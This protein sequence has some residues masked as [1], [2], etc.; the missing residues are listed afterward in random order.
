MSDDLYLFIDFDDTLSDA[1]T[2]GVQYVHALSERLASAYG[3][4][5]TAW[6]EALVPELGAG[7]AR[8]EAQF[9]GNPLGGYTAWLEEERARTAESLFRS[10]GRTLPPE[11]SPAE[12]AKRIQFDALTAVHAVYPGAAE[13]LKRLS[14]AGVRLMMAS[15]QDSY[16]LR[17][18]LTGAGI[19]ER[20]DTLYG[21]DL[22]DCAKEG[23]EFYRR[24]FEA[25][26]IRP[27]QAVVLDDQVMCLD[28]A[29]EAGARVV[30]ACVRADAEEP[31][32]PV[33]LTEFAQLPT[34]LRKG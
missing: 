22:V 18:A 11:E 17:G 21:P 2:F 20:F 1:K 28:W 27:S 3:G 14:E 7:I 25:S 33:V 15:S 10:V 12:L 31:E 13:A 16:F 32:F 24:L 9:L 5:V 4:E 34:L 26:G 6:T 8:Y 30:Q 19:V 29:E 23:T